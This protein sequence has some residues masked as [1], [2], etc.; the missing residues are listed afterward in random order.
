MK[1]AR[2]SSFKNLVH[3]LC[4][5]Q[6][7][8]ERVG[9]VVITNCYSEDINWAVMEVQSTQAL[10]KR[11]VSDK[12]YHLV[13]SFPEGER[14]SEAVLAKIEA[15]FCK[16]LGFTEHQRIRVVHL[17]TDNLHMHIAINKVHPTQL[18]L[19]EPYRDFKVRDALCVELENAF[20]LQKDNHRSKKSQIQSN[21]HDYETKSGIE[22]LLGYVQRTCLSKILVADS[23]AS[24]HNILATVGLS[25]KAKGNGLVFI[26]AEGVAVKASSV[27]KSC[28]KVAL[29]K[30]LGP[31][32]S[33][34][35]KV[36]KRTYTP[37]LLD[38]NVNSQALYKAYQT[39]KNE[40]YKNTYQAWE[41]LTAVPDKEIR[42]L[43]RQNKLSRKT[44]RFL[45][46]G[47]SYYQ[48]RY[49]HVLL[50][51]RIRQKL[52]GL[53]EQQKLN[54]EATYRQTKYPTFNKWVQKK[55]EEGSKEAQLFLQH[56][57]NLIPLQE[58]EHENERRVIT[59]KG[60]A[61]NDRRKQKQP[62]FQ[63]TVYQ[64]C[65]RRARGEP[66]TEHINAMPTLSHGHV[67]RQPIRSQMLLQDYAL[68]GVDEKGTYLDNR[69]RWQ[70]NQSSSSNE[71]GRVEASQYIEER[72]QKRQKG[73]N[74]LPHRLFTPDDN[75]S[76]VFKGLRRV[77]E[78]SLVLLT[79]KSEQLIVLPID[80]KVAN[81]LK[82]FSVG[83]QIHVNSQGEIRIKS[84]GHER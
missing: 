48:K 70:P 83:E 71:R 57:V 24:M 22:S 49:L 14:V 60:N 77:N 50:N 45:T 21:A 27:D 44:L 67:V 4:D 74:I 80:T 47:A 41:K 35:K 11:A 26:A 34:D 81:R 20:C 25:L 68:S 42:V 84:R 31:F 69:V 62:V 32:V 54:K 46:Q 40:N 3:Y 28:S 76:V 19:H 59:R 2:K 5:S 56:K 65:Y 17:D 51:Y 43:L 1:K 52:E 13:I 33:S 79:G 18:T 9:K 6:N 64:S 72:E 7:K 82:R 10:N 78:Q 30:R 8:Q 75:G 58:K 37:E 61:S 15:Q 39:A 53:L 29:E 73:M 12:T 66:P 16:K 36:N 55:A 38:K 23:W 63:Y